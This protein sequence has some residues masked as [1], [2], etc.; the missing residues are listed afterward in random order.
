MKRENRN[1]APPK[2]DANQK[3]HHEE[4]IRRG[5]DLGVGTAVRFMNYMGDADLAEVLLGDAKKKK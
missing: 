3:K 2:S 1:P 4:L 5:T